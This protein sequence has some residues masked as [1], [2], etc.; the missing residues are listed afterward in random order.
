MKTRH[1]R[2]PAVQSVEA[3]ELSNTR[4]AGCEATGGLGLK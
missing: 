2:G 3:I 4:P 1:E